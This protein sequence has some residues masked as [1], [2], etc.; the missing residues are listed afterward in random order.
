[1]NDSIIKH[2][3]N[4]YIGGSLNL[5]RGLSTNIYKT[6]GGRIGVH[7]YSTKK[8][9]K[10]RRFTNGLIIGFNMSLLPPKVLCFHNNKLVR[11]LRAIGGIFVI[12]LLGKWYG[13]YYIIVFPI[14]IFH[15]IYIILIKFCN[16]VYI[17]YLW[18]NGKLDVR[19]SPLDRLGSLGV[20]LVACTKGVCDLG[21]SVGG[22]IGLGLGIDEILTHF[23]REPV[24][25]N[26]V[27]SYFDE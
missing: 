23:G 7:F 18:R 17:V 14:A 10:L 3:N 6:M 2:N 24:F 9:T 26:T 21:I 8:D 15:L 19:N 27:G 1:V 25:K 16:V 20:K 5:N 22:A 13:D 12:I 4:R 11:I